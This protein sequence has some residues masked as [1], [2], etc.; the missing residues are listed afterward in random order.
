MAP[1]WR[2]LA[3]LTLARASMGF[4]FQ[5]VASAA[6]FLAADLGLDKTQ[7]GWLIGLYLL[8]GVVIALPGGLL[9]ARFGDKRV[10]LAGLGLMIVGGLWLAVAGSFAEAN[11]ARLV[12]G[13]GAVVLNVLLAKMVADWFEDRER[14][15]AMSILIN[16]WPIGIGIAL[17]LLGALAE[18]RGWHWAI[19][20]TALFAT[21]GFA[22]VLTAYSAPAKSP[23]P[24]VSGTGIGVL[25]GREW[26]LLVLASLPWVLYNAA[27][28]I[29]V[30]FLPF[31][32][33][34]SGLSVTRAGA[35]T[36]ANTV[37]FVLS[38]QAGGIILKRATHPDRICYA[39]IIGWS[40][41]LLLLSG[42]SAP[43]AWIV[44]GGL[45][46]GLPAGAFVTLP[47]EFL[48]AESRGAGMGV[49]FTIYYVGCAIL[50]SVAGA[51]YDLSGSA[52][53]TL[54]L[55]AFVALACFPAQL[56]FRRAL[57]LARR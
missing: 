45:L 56:A 23:S 17:V 8:P 6:P 47:T 25:T 11:A 39:A 57:E 51:L 33:L 26:R 55:A 22:A 54:W 28:Q 10:T 49:F 37:L 41:T 5:S 1:R 3:A 20:S 34:E 24:S 15:L 14:V 9:G 12:S 2:I 4:Q 48:R 29:V 52:R 40:A 43:M 19:V 16:S 31:F 44:L 36:A 7:L 13:V 21:L 46:G 50:P 27:Y 53:A 35:L 18:L 38:V 30:S 32:F 42:E